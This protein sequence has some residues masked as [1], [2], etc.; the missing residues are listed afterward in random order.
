M[1]MAEEGLQQ[2]RLEQKISFD[3][4]EK[5]ELRVAKIISVEDVPNADKLYRLEIDLG[6][7]KRQLV[8]GIKQDYSKEELAGKQVIVVANLQ[9]ARIKGIESNGMLLAVKAK[10]GYTLV[11]AD[12]EAEFS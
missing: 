1:K 3:D 5:I 8:A 7:E 11:T 6:S 2:K 12:R 10:E 9:P 4:F